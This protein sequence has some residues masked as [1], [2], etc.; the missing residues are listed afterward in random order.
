M[1]VDAA[2]AAPATRHYRDVTT[3][4]PESVRRPGPGLD[5]ANK[6]EL[7]RT[8]AGAET[9]ALPTPQTLAQP[10]LAAIGPLS[11]PSAAAPLD[12]G[13]L[14]TVLFLTGGI[15]RTRASGGDIRATAA[16]GALYPNEL[17]VVAG[18]LPGLPAGV[19]HYEPQAAHLARLRSGDWRGGVAVAADDP[20]IARAPAT[21]VATGILWRSAWKYRARAYRHLHWDGGMMAAHLLA[22]AAAT[23]MPATLRAAFVDRE[24][25]RL[26][27]LDGRRELTVA[28]VPLGVP[29]G[30]A[31]ASRDVPPLAWTPSS[32]SPR[33]LDYPEAQAYHTATQLAD[34]AAVR[35]IRTAQFQVPAHT[36]E[37]PVVALPVSA[38]SQIPLDTAVRRRSSARRF[39]HQPIAAA[40]LA[41]VLSAPASALAADFLH[42][43]G[44]LLETYV[45][46]NAVDGVL[47]G[48]YHYRRGERRLEQLRAGDLRDTAGFLCLEQAL[49]RDA[50]AVLF[51]MSP[52]DHVG[53]AFGERGYRFAE[54]EAGVRG[55]RAYLAARAVGVGAT[56][57]TFYDREVTRFFSPHAA[58]LEPLLVVAIGVPARRS[59]GG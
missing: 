40:Q 51:Y 36:T 13:T 56:G 31:A 58:K 41:A 4:T 57:L 19:Y 1:A 27:G 5:W 2:A 22:A 24:L 34:A 35:R 8:Y 29:A 17:Y 21:V 39:T 54:L 12:I 48:A 20:E 52:L 11:A 18:D 38:T 30:T 23:S 28:L 6:P 3:H 32:L 50:A 37:A 26:L 53:G 55:G 44:S 10:A 33:P 25:D 43:D 59:R 14:S 15:T 7:Y 9:V 49:A 16:A 42:G 47:A 45:I 46:V